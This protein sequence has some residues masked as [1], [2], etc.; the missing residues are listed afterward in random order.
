MPD[1]LRC[2]LVGCGGMGANQA[3]IVSGLEEYELAAVCDVDE[4]NAEKVGGSVGVKPYLDFTKALDEVKPDVVSVCTGNTTHAPLTI[5]A[6]HAGVRGVYCEKPMA[7]NIKDA[8]E[9]VATCLKTNTKL[10]VNHQRRLGA[11]LVKMKGL[12]ADGA[13]G[14]V[15]LIR[16]RCAGD[17]L[18]DGTHLVDSIM[19]LADDSEVLWILGQVHRDLEGLRL[20]AEKHGQPIDNV[21]FRYGHPVESGGMG[22]FQYKHGAR[23]EI[24]CG[25]MI[26]EGRAY[27]DYEVYG[28]RGRLWRTGDRIS[29]NLFLQDAHGGDWESGYVDWTYKPIICR[30]ATRGEWR[31]VELEPTFEGS[32]I[33][34]GYRRFARTIL[35]DEPHPM[36]GDVALGGLEVVMGVYE[37]ARLHKRVVPP[38]SQERF[39]LDVMIEEGRI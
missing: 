4:R 13:I 14:E 21:G 3:R 5:Q 2:L 17:I 11:D 29:P 35:N 24:F 26:E 12:I 23:A 10:V 30:T 27:Q 8:R 16:G 34:E 6:A 37:S 25:D 18:S 7:S 22:V 33:G 36:A 38:L 39:P 32:A 15:K 19:W 9:M 28:T 1:K 20:L 31:A